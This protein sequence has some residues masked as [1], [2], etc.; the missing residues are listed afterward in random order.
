[1]TD[2]KHADARSTRNDDIGCHVTVCADCHVV[3][4]VCF[5]PLPQSVEDVMEKVRSWGV[6]HAK[7]A[8]RLAD[9]AIL[10]DQ[11]EASIGV[12]RTALLNSRMSKNETLEAAAK[13]LEAR[14]MEDA[15]KFLRNLKLELAV[16]PAT[17]TP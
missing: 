4:H 13:E 1:M 15:A 9:Q 8:K 11:M 12:L 6:H 16:A 2:C 7:S 3:R 14:N 10:S 5:D 17:T